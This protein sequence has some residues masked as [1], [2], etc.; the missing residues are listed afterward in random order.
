MNLILWILL[1]LIINIFLNKQNPLMERENWIGTA[2]VIGLRSIS[3]AVVSNYVFGAGIFSLDPMTL[4]YLGILPIMFL[5][6]SKLFT[7]QLS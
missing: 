5:L 4:T 7:K 1:G 6:A 3:G 2:F